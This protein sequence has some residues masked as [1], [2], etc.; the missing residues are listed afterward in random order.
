MPNASI[1]IDWSILSNIGINAAKEKRDALA[2]TSGALDA[3]NSARGKG[4]PKWD[5]GGRSNVGINFYN[6]TGV[7]V[8][9]SGYEE[10]DPTAIENERV[11][12]FAPSLS[13]LLMKIGAKEMQIFGS[14]TAGLAPKIKSLTMSCMGLLQRLWS[15]RFV[16]GIGSGFT[17][18]ITFNGID[19]STGVFERTAVGAQSNTIGGLSKSTYSFAIGW[20]NVVA[21][22]ANAYGANQTQLYNAVVQT[23]KHKDG[24]KKVWVFSPQGMVNQKRAVQANER[25]M[26]AK[27]LDSGMPVEYY[28]GIR[29]FMEPQMP[30]STASG[31]SAT[32]T[33]PITAYLWDCDDIFVKWSKAVKTDAFTL[34]DGFFGMGDWRQI[35]GEQLV[36]GCPIMVGGQTIVTDMGSSAVVIRGETY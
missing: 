24:G 29:M 5:D 27:A 21:D 28:H 13:G 26:S 2:L 35:S 6:T 20:Q 30:V 19:F 3:L 32:Q 23:K 36:M 22:M 4:T 16:A 1:N 25:Y 15:Q 14:T 7:T 11:A 10:F 31:G 34:P 18:W 8:F 12:Q 9:A 33:Y 17:D